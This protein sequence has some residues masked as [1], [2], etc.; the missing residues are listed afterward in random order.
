MKKFL[1]SLCPHGGASSH[2]PQ[3]HRVSTQEICRQSCIQ[4]ITYREG[5]G[6]GGRQRISLADRGRG[7]KEWINT[8]E[9]TEEGQN[10]RGG[11][12]WRRRSKCKKK[13]KKTVAIKEK[14]LGE[15]KSLAQKK[16]IMKSRVTE[17]N[18]A[19]QANEEGKE[20]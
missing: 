6:D 11:R 14:R 15:I 12:D 16:T 4:L 17:K 18:V 5:D 2:T 10:E 19:V 20:R 3:D 1:V 9:R 13:T 7:G 8:T